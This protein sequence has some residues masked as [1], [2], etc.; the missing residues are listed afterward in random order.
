M[1]LSDALY[2]LAGPL[3]LNADDLLRYAAE[4][5]VGGFHLDLDKRRWTTGSIWEGEG[6]FVYALV[7]ALQPARILECG[8]GNGCTSAHLLAALDANGNGDLVSVDPYA[9]NPA[10]M[11]DHPR[12]HRI[13]GAGETYLADHPDD[14]FELVIEDTMH[15]HQMTYDILSRAHRPGLRLALAHDAGHHLVGADVTSGFIA[16]LGSCTTLM[17][18]DSDCGWGCWVN[19]DPG[20]PALPVQTVTV[21]RPDWERILYLPIIEPG[22]FHDTA[23]ANKRGLYDALLEAG[24]PTIQLDYLAEPPATLYQT[25]TDLIARHG[26]TFLLTQ[27]HSAEHLTPVQLVALKAKFPHMRTVNWSGDSW[28]HSLTSDP[29]L[30]L[31]R[32]YD[33]W[34]VAAPD[35]LPVYEAQGIRAAFWQ[36]AY[37]RPVG[38]LPEMPSYDVVFLGNVI[39]DKRR[40]LM[41]FLRALGGVSVG[42]YGDWEHADGNN[43][44]DFGAG[45]ALYQHAKIAIADNPYPDQVNY[46]SNR[47]IQALMAGGAVLLHQHVPKMDTLL[48]IQPGLHFVEWTDFA[49]LGVSIRRYLK[50]GNEPRRR[51]LVLAGQ[52]YAQQHHTY[53]ARVRELFDEILPEAVQ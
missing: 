30:A 49:D 20:E 4:D 23:L 51:K 40:A 2:Q 22:A 7:R 47:P 11:N 3:G 48:G 36:I 33:R 46:T 35:V 1:N 19:P 27:F 37:E 18:D 5:H 38:V 12:W 24:Y 10:S 50:K 26:I 43:L 15:T 32:Q 53:A 41:E 25:V 31:A 8:I 34:L 29:V 9:L 45:D 39:S 28:L 16:A 42:I 21:E 13:N 17:I 52:V 6:R 14:R 44:Y